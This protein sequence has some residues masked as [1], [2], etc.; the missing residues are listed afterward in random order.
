ME[1]ITPNT[2]E[3]WSKREAKTWLN[4]A[5]GDDVDVRNVGGDGEIFIKWNGMNRR[6]VFA[7]L[8]EHGWAVTSID[9]NG[10]WLERLDR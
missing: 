10:T 8:L 2:G 3:P 1:K 9:C 7:R 5:A 6:E 4:E